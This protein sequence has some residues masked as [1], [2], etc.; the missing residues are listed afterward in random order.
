MAASGG[1]TDLPLVAHRWATSGLS[2]GKLGF[3]VEK[4]Y[5]NFSINFQPYVTK[6]SCLK[7]NYLYCWKPTGNLVL[8]VLV[9]HDYFFLFTFN[10]EN[11]SAS[12]FSAKSPV[13]LV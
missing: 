8:I 11:K 9:R 13:F 12:I 10:V 1:P 2:S 4:V 7:P 6:K 5:I 3:T